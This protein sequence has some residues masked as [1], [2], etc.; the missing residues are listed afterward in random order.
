MCPA[1][2]AKDST[3]DCKKIQFN[4]VLKKNNS[5]KDPKKLQINTFF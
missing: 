5:T 1:Q 2:K 3:K 4:A